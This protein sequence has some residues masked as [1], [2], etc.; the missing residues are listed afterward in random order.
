LDIRHLLDRDWKVTLEH[1]LRD[2]I[3]YYLFYLKNLSSHLYWQQSLKSQKIFYTNKINLIFE[4]HSKIHLKFVEILYFLIN[5]GVRVS[6]RASRLI[7]Q[8]LKLTTM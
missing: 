2:E 4:K 5:V 7:P 6:L 8:A 1:A 3:L